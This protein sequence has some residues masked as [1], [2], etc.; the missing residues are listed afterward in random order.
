V[1]AF[2]EHKLKSTRS[3]DL[4]PIIETPHFILVHTLRSDVVL[5]T[6]IEKETQPLFVLEIH[7]KIMASLYHYLGPKITPRSIRDHFALVYHLLDEMVDGG[8]PFT[9][10]NNQLL[11]MI[12]PP[13]LVNKVIQTFATKFAV[14]KALPDGMMTKIPW[15][16]A[17]RAY[18]INRISF[19]I[20]E[21][22]NCVTHGEHKVSNCE[23]KGS[24]IC[25]SRLSGTPDVSLTFNRPYLVTDAVL[26]RCVRIRTFRNSARLSY[27]PP[28]GR[29]TLLTYFLRRPCELPIYVKPNITYTLSGTAS[30]HIVIGLKRPV[31][32]EDV[33]ITIVFPKEMINSNLKPSIGTI[34]NN[35]T[36]MGSYREV[37]WIIE[38]MPRNEA[39]VLSGSAMFKAG[40]K[41]TYKPKLSVNFVGKCWNTSGLAVDK[42]DVKGLKHQPTK[43]FTLETRTG[44]FHLRCE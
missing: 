28:D 17:G 33:K 34:K 37:H 20:L 12:Q 3:V 25:D 23:V 32:V 5:L 26:H 9:T 10:E 14:K 6:A 13:T 35:E 19:F 8:Y 2:A 31:I 15:R 21:E 22:I 39:P 43:E 30:V 4:L 38:K 36:Q 42:V 29:F 16:R 41:P 11:A 27:I 44:K 1:E 7:N 18:A 40:F 24:V